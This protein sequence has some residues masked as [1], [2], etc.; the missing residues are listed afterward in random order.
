MVIMMMAICNETYKP[1]NNRD[2]ALVCHRFLFAPSICRLRPI[3]EPGD[4]AMFAIM[5]NIVE[6]W[7][8]N[9]CE[10]L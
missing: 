9:T 10:H 4:E 2:Q 7:I 8:G 5:D 6:N 1:Q 3:R